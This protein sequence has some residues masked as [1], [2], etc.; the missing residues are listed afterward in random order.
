M[1]TVRG[2]CAMQLKKC[3]TEEGCGYHTHG[4]IVNVGLLLR[5]WKFQYL[6]RVVECDAIDI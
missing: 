5:A 3:R 1:E 4:V 6:R 2:M